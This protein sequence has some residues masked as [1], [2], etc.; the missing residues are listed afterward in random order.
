[1]TPPDPASA[2]PLPATLRWAV[3]LLSAQATA[4][5][6]VTGYLIVQDV[7]ATP[8][9]RTVAV[10][11]TLFA[12]LGALVLGAVARALSRRRAGARGP[13]VVLQLMLLVLGYYMVQGGLVW[14]GVL[15]LAVGLCTGVLIVSPAS[16]RALGLG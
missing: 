9:D 2:E 10:G 14:L 11:V 5:A 16:T 7:T 3:W 1:V 4:T 15:L 12:A 6:L 13:A 8:T